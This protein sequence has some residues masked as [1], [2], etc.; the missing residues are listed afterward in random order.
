MA[1]VFFRTILNGVYQGKDT[2]GNKYYQSRL[3]WGRPKPKRWVVYKNTPEASMIPPEWYGW[4]HHTT[5]APLDVTRHSWQRDHQ[6]NLTHTTEAFQPKP[7]PIKPDY[8]S[9][10]PN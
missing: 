8:K 7:A 2:F 4:L 9:W 5:D 10:I 1:T 3:H 6:P